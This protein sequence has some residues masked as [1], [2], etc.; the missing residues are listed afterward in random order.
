MMLRGRVVALVLIAIGAQLVE[1]GATT[2]QHMLAAAACIGAL[3][4]HVGLW[5][6]PMRWPRRLLTAV[7]A[8]VV[9]DAGLILL[10]SELSGGADGTGLWLLPLLALAV[11]LGHSPGFG[12]KALILGGIVMGALYAREEPGAPGLDET[13]GPLVLTASVVVIAAVFAEL[14]GRETRRELARLNG[15]WAASAALTTASE[16]DDVIAIVRTAFEGLLPD[17]NVSVGLGGGEAAERTWRADGRV[18]LEVPLVAPDGDGARAVGR[19]TA[20]R[21][22]PR[23]GPASVRSR[24]MGAIREVAADGGAALARIEAVE[25]L[26][27]LT[28]A[29]ALTGLGNRRAFDEALSSEAARASRAGEALGLIMLDVDHFK[30]VNDRHGHQAGD[31]AL[32]TVARALDRTAR[33]GDRACR[34]GGE[35]FALLLPGADAAAAAVVAERI[36]TAIANAAT[37]AGPVTVSLGVASTGPGGDVDDLVREADANLYAAKERGRNR[38]VTTTA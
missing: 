21:P 9:V 31:A 20:S 29:D 10:L 16:P 12:V 18:M 3:A 34:I 26:E 8:A 13:A 23:V 11:T 32:V 1:P 37:P 24:G 14:D 19:L 5:L 27:R 17:W 30:R 15:K 22:V 25:R 36:R 28:L 38:V 6:A 2:R 35:E 4:V 7:D 33:A